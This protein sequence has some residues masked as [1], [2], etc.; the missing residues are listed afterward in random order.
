MRAQHVTDTLR[1]QVA[2]HLGELIWDSA[3]ASADQA[4]VTVRCDSLA[5]VLAIA[6]KCVASHRSRAR[7]SADA[8]AALAELRAVL[9][10]AARS[11][12]ANETK[13]ETRRPTDGWVRS[14]G[15]ASSQ[16]KVAEDARFELARGCP[17][18]AFQV[19]APAFMVGRASP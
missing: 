12:I 2:S 16:V 11:E 7:Q 13:T 8:L 1:S 3:A 18:H 14:T 15:F 9:P 5:A 10:G 4:V 17:Q 6:E 19:C